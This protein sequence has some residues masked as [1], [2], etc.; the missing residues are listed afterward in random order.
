M[1]KDI[2]ILVW[3]LETTGFTAPVDRILEIG[4]FIVRGNEVERKH[5]VLDNKCVI[6]DNIVEITG[7]TQEIID[8]EGR[9]P[10]ECLNEFLPLFKRAKANLTHNGIRFDIPFLTAYAADV[11]QWNNVSL[12]TVRNMLRSTAIDTAVNFKAKQLGMEQRENE[13]FVAFADRVM[14]IR[15][16]GVKFNLGLCVESLGIKSDLVQHRAMADVELTHEVLS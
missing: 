3:D 8:Q 4:C 9:D 6:P 7:I 12:E 14:S 16:Y 5:W 1:E 15:A 10:V 13:P 11:L 2:D